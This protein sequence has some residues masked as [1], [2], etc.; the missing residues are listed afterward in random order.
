[1][2]GKKVKNLFGD[3]FIFNVLKVIY[4]RSHTISSRNKWKRLLKNSKSGIRLNLG[5]GV[6]KGNGYW[7]TVDLVGSDINWDLR[8]G[9]PLPDN[10]VDEVYCSH[11]LEHIPY[12][13]IKIFLLEV[14]R[15]LKQ[16][17]AFKVAVPNARIYIEA[18]V[19]KKPIPTE[20]ILYTPALV[21]TGSFMDHI[22]YIAYMSGSHAYMFDEEN[23]INT[24]KLGK[25]TSIEY[26]DFESCL[27]VKDRHA[28]SIYAVCIK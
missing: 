15:V 5:S 3:G 2:N 11:L 1:M 13:Q 9:I 26:R 12:P 7:T 19:A 16:S 18:Y 27:D 28:E 21:K 25:F 8:R 23:L 20:I 14:R 4:Y 6:T 22:N 10:S 24:L 17:G